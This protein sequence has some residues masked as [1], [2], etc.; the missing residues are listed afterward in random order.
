MKF[1]FLLCIVSLIFNASLV[2]SQNPTN[3]EALAL[4]FYQR[5]DYQNAASIY[6]KLYYRNA[7]TYIYDNF[8]N[9]LIKINKF[10]EAEKLISTQ[11]KNNPSAR[12]YIDLLEVYELQNDN[13]KFQKTWEDILNIAANNEVAYLDLAQACEFKNKIDWSIKILEAGAKAL[14][15]SKQIN[16]NLAIKYVIAKDYKNATL[17]ITNLIKDFSGEKDWLI[18]VFTSVMQVDRS[19]EFTPILKNILLDFISN[20]PKSQ[21]YNELLIWFYNQTGNFEAAINQAVAFEKRTNG[22]GQILFELGNDLLNIGKNQL[23]INAFEKLITQFPNSP[24]TLKA[25]VLLLN[26]KMKNVL[27]HSNIDALE[28]NN[29]NNEIEKFIYEYPEFRYQ[30]E[31]MINYSKILC[32]YLHDCNKALNNLQE[33]LKKIVSVT[34]IQA[35]VKFAMADI[36]LAMDNP[37]D[38]ILLCGQV[39]KDFKEDTTG[40]YAKYYKAYI[41]YLMGDIQFAKAQFDALKGSTTKFVANDAINKSVFIQENIA[42]DSSYVPLQY[43]AKAEYMEHIFDF[44]S[45]LNYLDTILIKYSSHPIID[46]VLLKKAQ[47]YKK[48]SQYDLAIAELT[49]IIDNYYY[50]VKADDALYDLA[51]IYSDIYKN[52]DKAK[53]LLLQLITDFPVSIYVDMARLQLNKFKNNS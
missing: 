48:L 31:F 16:E 8:L 41:Y 30:P 29:L 22:Q 24:Y 12:Y 2:L 21:L 45:A 49:K 11:L 53:E 35:Q 37:W 6:E 23:A 50:E 28:I 27:S 15:L 51:M 44:K 1:R 14:P 18:K 5:G 36:Y 52:Y 34:P 46:D 38:A 4:E 9:S 3:D 7:N 25:R 19:D 20:N 39:E 43:Y 47:I 10:K 17:L 33:I 13:K 42:F 32:F 40:Y 26:E